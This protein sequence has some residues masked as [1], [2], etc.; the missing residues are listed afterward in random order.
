[1]KWGEGRLH[2]PSWWRSLSGVAPDR[3]QLPQKP[4]LPILN[5]KFFSPS[6]CFNAGGLFSTVSLFWIYQ[7]GGC[8]WAL[9]SRRRRFITLERFSFRATIVARPQ[10]V[11]PIIWVKSGLHWKWSFQ[12]VDRGLNSGVSCWVSGSM[13]LVLICLLPLQPWQAQ[14]RLSK[15]L[16]PPDCL[17]SVWS[18]VKLS[19]E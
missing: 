6:C 3:S 1:M 10:A 9:V 16:S 19:G 7:L 14:A 13:K 2:F 15:V 11:I 12:A 8:S 4:R 5:S 17:G 18:I